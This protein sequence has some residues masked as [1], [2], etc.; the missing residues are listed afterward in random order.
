VRLAL[1][2]LC[3]CAQVAGI[4][5]TSSAPDAAPA[6]DATDAPIDALS[7]TGGDARVTDPMTGACYLFFAS[8]MTRPAARTVCQGLGPTTR[9]ASIQSEAE[10][11]LVAGLIG[12]NEAFLGGTDEV[13]EGSFVWDDGT[14]VVLTNWNTGE[15]NNALGMFEED[16][17]VMIGALGGKWDDRPCAPPPVDTG[18]Y[19][20][21]CERD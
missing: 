3:G 15:P 8:P 4:E 6:V 21:V 14:A 17:V 1:V 10:S 11:T 5:R 13:L 9:L 18:A 2:L 7:C 12:M 20:F 16:C 19:G